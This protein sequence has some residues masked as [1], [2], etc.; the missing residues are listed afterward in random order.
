MHMYHQ[1]CIGISNNRKSTEQTNKSKDTNRQKKE[2]K[3]R[4]EKKTR[5]SKGVPLC[6]VNTKHNLAEHMF[7]SYEFHWDELKH[8]RWSE[9]L[10]MLTL[11]EHKFALQKFTNLGQGKITNL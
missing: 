2:K 4:S 11:S 10:K 9:H 3:R 8:T 7:A 5:R 6:A 1:Q